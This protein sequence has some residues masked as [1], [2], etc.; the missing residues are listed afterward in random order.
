MRSVRRLDVVVFDN[1]FATT[2]IDRVFGELLLLGFRE[3]DALWLSHAFRQVGLIDRN[4][5][6]V[7]KRKRR[8]LGGVQVH[9]ATQPIGMLR[10]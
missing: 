1:R 7:R 2:G 6:I 10:A 8:V 9:Q 5:P 3:Y 4:K